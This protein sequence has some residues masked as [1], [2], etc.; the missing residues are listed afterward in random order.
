V[1]ASGEAGEHAGGSGF[2]NLFW[3][4]QAGILNAE[5][6]G[7]VSQYSRGGVCTRAQ[8][9]R[10]PFYHFEKPWNAAG[11]QHF[12]RLT[13]ADFFPLSGWTR[14]VEGLDPDTSFNCQT[15]FNIHPGWLRLFGGK[16]KWGHYVHEAA[17]DAFD[18]GAITHSAVSMHFVDN[19]PGYDTGPLIFQ[20][21]VPIVFPV[22]VPLTREQKV[23]IVARSVNQFEVYC[24]PRVTNLVVNR[25]IIWNGVDHGSVIVPKGY[26]IRCVNPILEL[27][28][29]QV[30]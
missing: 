18:E 3:A 28:C 13:K 2:E 25:H 8:R 30:G 5:I 20:V 22:G 4:I 12:A 7:V 15:V 27:G 19:S 21:S 23:K 9:L 10:V 24:Q 11:Y 1:Y 6:V 17:V 26:S 29:L 16:G 14:F